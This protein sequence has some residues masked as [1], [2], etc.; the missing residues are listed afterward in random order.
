MTRSWVLLPCFSFFSSSY[1][2]IIISLSQLSFFSLG[3]VLFPPSPVCRY[4][5]P[6]SYRS[7]LTLYKGTLLY[8]LFRIT[9]WGVT[10][11]LSCTVDIVVSDVL[12]LR[13]KLAIESWMQLSSSTAACCWAWRGFTTAVSVTH[14]A[15]RG[16]DS[17][18]LQHV[19]FCSLFNFF[20]SNCFLTFFLH[21]KYIY[22]FLH[23]K[24]ISNFF[25]HFNFL[26]SVLKILSGLP[27]G[28]IPHSRFTPDILFSALHP[29]EPR[30][31]RQEPRWCQ[32]HGEGSSGGR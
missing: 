29:P 24:Y 28:L 22:F 32:R 10:K 14:G 31:A 26:F 9:F 30:V 25:L 17:W 21:F 6:S 27:Q 5:R 19:I 20:Q 16:S 7:S 4:L 11:C 13:L 23:F 15:L 3:R 18:T 12:P 1:V 2:I 8:L